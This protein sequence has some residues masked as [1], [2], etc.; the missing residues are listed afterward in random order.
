MDIATKQ[1]D[2]IIIGEEL[3]H[4]V[5]EE[6]IP[7]L[8]KK[9]SA[10]LKSFFENMR[11]YILEHTKN[12]DWF[13]I[14][15]QDLLYNNAVAALFPNLN[16]FDLGHCSINRS[17]DPITFHN[18]FG[19]YTGTLMTP[20]EFKRA[21]A[22]KF[23]K[24]YEFCPEYLFD[25]FFTVMDFH[26]AL[27]ADG[28]RS[29]R[30][31]G[32]SKTESYHIPLYRL[33]GMDSE[34]ISPAK[35]IFFWLDNNLFPNDLP[36]ALV[37]TYEH[38]LSLYHANKDCFEW[39]DDTIQIREDVILDSIMD[40]TVNFFSEDSYRSSF[41]YN[42]DEKTISLDNLSPSTLQI[43]KEHLLTCDQR[44]ADFERYD[45][46]I[47]IDPNRGHWSLWQDENTV[48]KYTAKI[49]QPMIARNPLAD[50]NTDGIIGIDFGTKSTVVAYQDNMERIIPMRI[51]TS[52]YSKKADI[53]QY[54]NPTVM[55]LIDLKHFFELYHKK[56]GRPD[57]LWEDLTV[58]HSAVSSMMNSTSNDYY[59]FFNELKQWAGNQK[60]QIRLKDKTGNDISLPPFSEIGENDF[61][62][63]EIYAYYIG[64]AIN[65]M[66]NGIFLNYLLS[67]PVT[68]EQATC[69]KIVKSF[70][71]GIRKSLPESILH[72]EEIM[73]NF[74]VLKGTSEP[75]AYAICALEE[76][77]FDL[78]GEE[79]EIY[80]GIFDFGGGTTD[81]DFGHW[82]TPEPA[83]S[84]RY[85]YVLECYGS[86]GDQYLGG[87]NLLQLMSYE[88][89]RSN[90]DKLREDNIT[91]SLP[92]ECH[93]FPGSESLISN[94]QEAKLNTR[95][96]MEKLRP[97]WERDKNYPSLYQSGKIKLALVTRS[98]E[99]KLNY[100]LD[101]NIN[102]LDKLLHKRIELGIANFFECLKATFKEKL[103]NDIQCVHI[104]LAGNGSRSQILTSLFETYM[105]T[106]ATDLQHHI[107]DSI[108]NDFFRLHPALGMQE[109]EPKEMASPKATIGNL[110]HQ[111]G[112]ISELTQSLS[113][114]GDLA[115]SVSD[116]SEIT[117][118]KRQLTDDEEDISA[119]TKPNGKTGVAFGLLE[120]RPGGRIK[121]ILPLSQD[122][123]KD[124]SDIRFRFYIGYKKKNTFQMISGPS[125][126]YNKWTYLCD[127]STEDFAIY[128]TPRSE[129]AG[130]T[131]SIFD[132][133]KKNCRLNKAYENASIYY[134][135]IA[136]DTIE[137]TVISNDNFDSA[138][139][140][141]NVVKVELNY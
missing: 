1:V 127:A 107:G 123:A 35:T 93:P 2:K 39:I 139:L 134:R 45:E 141:E 16:T 109:A 103:G 4:E 74:R 76:Y 136:P 102:V 3:F 26:R 52:H 132:V 89:F 15:N 21:F 80:Y 111:S 78:E 43:V 87:E 125:L 22:G 92:P 77:G 6:H 24:L 58:S 85:D 112:S 34:T 72:N 130:G 124:S 67:F 121:I 115:Q 55:E 57:T 70:Y 47:L 41:L 29:K 69:D 50:V 79:K 53:M 96:L 97:F 84:R 86:G 113:D 25:S 19:S 42:A 83:D 82:H 110:A 90:Q 11:S 49:D 65:N 48:C 126:P 63:I 20:N 5:V 23:D 91:F 114:I 46:N 116:I 61:N 56:E 73:K 7:A 17:Y 120:G 51:G 8:I 98:G 106:Y 30:W 14:G 138:K 108:S 54:E 117:Q 32:F 129:A 44:R 95:Q 13:Y 133:Y 94:S 10:L 38:V 28:I 9:Q 33:N 131:L 118:N 40:G 12:S 37:P 36:S 140:L 59:S 135:A 100:E 122:V 27:H 119:I 128:Y 137:Y 31:N 75:A 88:V 105:V 64:L 101:V 68:F 81:F 60:K 71:R 62:P 104:F 66:N 99:Q 18:E